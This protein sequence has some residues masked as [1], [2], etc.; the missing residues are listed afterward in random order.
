M[1]VYATSEVILHKAKPDVTCALAKLNMPAYL[2]LGSNYALAFTCSVNILV[3]FM[4]RVSRVIFTGTCP[5]VDGLTNSYTL[6]SPRSSKDLGASNSTSPSIFILASPSPLAL[7]IILPH[8]PT[9]SS[10]ASTP[11]TASR[12]AINSSM[13]LATSWRPS[14]A[15]IHKRPHNVEASCHDCSLRSS[16]RILNQ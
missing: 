5:D 3:T 4:L 12:D 13:V 7:T 1:R 9:C 8:S 16:L 10:G 14:P 11:R 2:K 15:T 6:F